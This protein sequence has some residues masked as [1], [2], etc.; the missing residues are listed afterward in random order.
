MIADLGDLIGA[1]GPRLRALRLTR[2]MTLTAVAE[3]SG[4][5]VSTLSRVE[6]GKRQPTLDVLLPLARVY[7][8]SLDQLVDA[9]P[10]GDPRVHLEPRSMA[11]GGV[12]VPLTDY[13]GR[14]RAFKHVLGPREPRLATHDGHAWLYVLAGRLRLLLADAE[15]I[16]EP[17]ETAQFDPTTPHWF[18]PADDN[19]VEILHLFGPHGDRPVSRLDDVSPQ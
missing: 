13:P 8:V 9:P 2:A 3:E 5:S 11:S 16:L 10:T 14:V 18:G 6:T 4:L 7:R 12:I 1:I 19:P 15:H 17:G